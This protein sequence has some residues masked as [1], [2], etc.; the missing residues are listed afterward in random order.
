MEKRLESLKIALHLEWGELADL[1]GISRS[2]L[3]Q[4]RKGRRAFGP[5]IMRKLQ[6]AEVEAGIRE[7][8]RTVVVVHE[9]QSSGDT[10]SPLTLEALRD[11]L[12]EEFRKLRR[13]IRAMKKEMKP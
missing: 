8:P 6:Q 4:T 2:M 10:D 7:P 13:E 1:L 12:A 5:H 11:Y 3:D 9:K